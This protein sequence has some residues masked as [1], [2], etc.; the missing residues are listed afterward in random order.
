MDTHSREHNCANMKVRV[1]IHQMILT[2]N[3]FFLVFQDQ[4]S[5]HDHTSLSFEEVVKKIRTLQRKKEAT[6]IALHNEVIQWRLKDLRGSCDRGD[7]D[8]AYELI[9]EFV[10]LHEK[11]DEVLDR[12]KAE[13]DRLVAEHETSKRYNDDSKRG[14]VSEEADIELDPML[15]RRKNYFGKFNERH[16]KV[17]LFVLGEIQECR[18]MVEDFYEKVANT[19]DLNKE[20]SVMQFELQL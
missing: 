6:Q 15:L 10:T 7:R 3:F 13:I 17:L 11:L 14:M 19:P 8:R 9:K 1:S 4:D 18:R 12:E 16:V 5:E 20:N 2:I